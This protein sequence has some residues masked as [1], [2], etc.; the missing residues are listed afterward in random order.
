MDAVV[1]QPPAIYCLGETKLPAGV[2][3]WLPEGW[4]MLSLAREHPGADRRQH[5][6]VALIFPPGM[7]ATKLTVPTA[8]GSA[9]D[10]LLFCTSIFCICICIC[11]LLSHVTGV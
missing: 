4:T 5:G 11:I 6:G 10:D 2:S 3:P 8:N 9:P 7:V 1:D